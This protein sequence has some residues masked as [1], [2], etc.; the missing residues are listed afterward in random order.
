MLKMA[1]MKLTRRILI[2][3]AL[4]GC[5]V[6]V[7]RMLPSRAEQWGE[8]D[9][10]FEARMDICED[11]FWECLFGGAPLPEGQTCSGAFNQCMNNAITEHTNCLA[12]QPG[13][14]SGGGQGQ[15]TAC[16]QGCDQVYWD[17]V[18]F[19]GYNTSSYQT[20]IEASDGNIDDCCYAER[21]Y[22]MTANCS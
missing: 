17:C 20:C 15:R 7:E 13:G 10:V 12:G 14:P 11:N 2:L 4:V 21:V 18:D 22:C 3:I 19:G 16:I 9:A 1:K 8:C 5:F 6:F